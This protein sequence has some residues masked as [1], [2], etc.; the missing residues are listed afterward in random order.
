MSEQNLSPAESEAIAKAI[1]EELARR[2]MSRQQLADVAKISLS[3]L[4]KALSGQRPLTIATAVRLE[5]AL[6]RSLRAGNVADVSRI[7]GI[8]PE[9]LG[10]YARPSVQWIEGDYLTIRPSFSTPG[11]YYAYRTSILWEPVKSHLIFC[12]SE[13]LDVAFTQEGEVSVPHQ[14]GFVYLVTNKVG[15]Y[16]LAI[17][18]KP[19]IAG[20]MFGILTTLQSG[21]GPQLLPVSTPIVFVPMAKGGDHPFGKIEPGSPHHA[22]CE[23]LI[24]RTIEEPFVFFSH[25]R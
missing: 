7:P 5:E 19:T 17:L 6:K 23:S 15:Q 16:R 14:S 11:A 24:R 25:G 20:E 12:E 21:R 22:R 8:A 10:S 13:R 1:R 2:R 18:S 4:E 9:A 3:T